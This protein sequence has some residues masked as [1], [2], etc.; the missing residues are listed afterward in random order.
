MKKEEILQVLP[1]RLQ[2][3][4]DHAIT[5]WNTLQEIHIRSGRQIVLTIQG[6]KR[7]PD[8]NG[9]VVSQ[10]EFRECLEH[11][12][13]YSLYAFEEEIRKGYLTIPGG[14]RIGVAGRIVMAENTIQTMRNISFMHIRI[15]HER[16]GC[17][18]RIMPYLYERGNF[19]S[20]LILSP[21]GAGK[22]TLLRD[23]VRHVATG[24]R[25]VSGK[26]VSVVDERSEIAGCCL[27]IPQKDV[28]LFTDVLDACPKA[29]G[30][31]MAIRSLSPEV[32]AVDEI[33]GA[34]EEEAL[35][36]ALTG[37]CALLATIHG[38]SL[39]DL[40]N[41]PWIGRIM[42]Q[43]MFQ[44]IIVLEK[45]ERP[46]IIQSVYDGKGQVIGH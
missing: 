13:N 38:E 23:I 25:M 19:L 9:Q 30:I 11:V 18:D 12:S 6:R 1:V 5:D 2:K 16:K 24:G 21:P 14:H 4:V 34:K 10:R 26:N 36:M 17:A 42:R 40:H 31:V 44:R 39:Q 46:G 8:Q 45:K 37:G 27:G 22:T 35:Q 15:S 29:E 33:G 28:G 43:N 20:T 41:S 7:F 3:I 32:I